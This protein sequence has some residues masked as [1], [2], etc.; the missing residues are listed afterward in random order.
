MIF[1][2]VCLFSGFSTVLILSNGCPSM[3][4]LQSYW[5]ICLKC[6]I[7]IFSGVC[8]FSGF[9]TVPIL[10][11]GCPLC[12]SVVLLICTQNVTLWN[13][14]A[15]VYLVDFQQFQFQTMDALF[16]CSVVLLVFSR[17]AAK[18]VTFSEFEQ[19]PNTNPKFKLRTHSLLVLL[20][21]RFF[22]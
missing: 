21:Y 6:N 13:F 19:T 7:V 5:L 11:N 3:F 22:V 14:S 9:S 17:N 8:L 16:I 18:I 2:G 4:V 12:F 1:F 15:F 20:S 10:S